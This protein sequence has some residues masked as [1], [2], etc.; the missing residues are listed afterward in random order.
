MGTIV[1]KPRGGSRT[2]V[3]GGVSLKIFIVLHLAENDAVQ[4]L[5]LYFKRKFLA[6][7]AQK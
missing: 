3:W 4:Y 7:Y 6:F 2:L 5:F 1:P